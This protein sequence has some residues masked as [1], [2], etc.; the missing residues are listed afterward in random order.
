MK[1]NMSINKIKQV[2]AVLVC[3][4]LLGGLSSPL[5][6]GGYEEA[7]EGEG[8][9]EIQLN[10]YG[11]NQFGAV[12][13]FDFLLTKVA[14]VETL[15]QTNTKIIPTSPDEC[16]AEWMISLVNGD[17][18]YLQSELHKIINELDP[19]GQNDILYEAPFI[20]MK[21]DLELVKRIIPVNATLDY[22]AFG[23]EGR[24]PER[25]AAVD[26]VMGNDSM[27]PW[28]ALPGGGFE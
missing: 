4:V 23:V 16:R 18:E 7:V 14:G 28:Y 11:V 9:N 3:L 6:A 13:L 26:P 1:N 8:A 22:V 27:A 24:I 25:I 21:E 2:I 10:L 15:E 12:Q 17:V 20:V 5:Y 19:D